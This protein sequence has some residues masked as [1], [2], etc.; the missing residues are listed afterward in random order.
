MRR[1]Y[2]FSHAVRLPDPKV[3]R[4]T[5]PRRILKKHKV[6]HNGTQLTKWQMREV[7]RRYADLK[8]PVRYLLVS[9][10]GR[11]S[12]LYYNVSD[13]VYA[14]ND[15]AAGTLFKRRS[16][17]IAVRNLLGDRVR[18]VKCVTKRHQGRRVPLPLSKLRR[19]GQT[20][21]SG[22]DTAQPDALKVCARPDAAPLPRSC[23]G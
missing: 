10:L 21:R 14:M 11:R 6:Q 12:T 22:L 16:A 8:D 19:S 4:T 1:E 9:D 13:D 18:V 17:A 7:K 23:R 20:R 15:A 3:R 5:V 2:D